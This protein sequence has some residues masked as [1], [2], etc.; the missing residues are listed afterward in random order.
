MGFCEGLSPSYALG[1]KDVDGRDKPGHDE[2][3][4]F[5]IAC[6]PSFCAAATAA[7]LPS[8]PAVR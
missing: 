3:K 2:S 4:L 7:D 1:K 6:A 8:A 5:S